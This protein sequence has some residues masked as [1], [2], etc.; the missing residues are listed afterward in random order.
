MNTNLVRDHLVYMNAKVS[1]GIM[2]RCC[3]CKEFI[4][5]PQLWQ[6]ED[7]SLIRAGV[8]PICVACLALVW[9]SGMGDIAGIRPRD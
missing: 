8:K 4:P 2:K 1:W 6:P 7:R 3:D 5:L 9:L